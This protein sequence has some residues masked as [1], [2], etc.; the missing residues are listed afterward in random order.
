L[1]PIDYAELARNR[2]WLVSWQ[3]EQWNRKEDGLR[4]NLGS[5]RGR[6]NGYINVDLY[7]EESDVKE[8]IRK[9]SYAKNSVTEIVCHHSLEHLPIRDVYPTLKHWFELLVPNGTIEVGLPDFELS[10]QAFLEA[11]EKDRWEKHIYKVFGGQTENQKFSM[12]GNS[13]PK[14]YFDYAEGQVHRG[15]FSLGYFVRMVEDAGFKIINAFNYDAYGSPSLFVYAMKPDIKKYIYNSLLE[16]DCAIGV[17]THRTTYLPIL[18]AST[19]KYFPQVQFITRINRGMI[20]Q[21]MSLLRE[22]FIKSGKR[23]WIYLDDDIQFLNSN[24]IKNALET[25]VGEKYACVSVY[26]TFE[27]IALD[28]KYNPQREGVEKRSTKWATGYF[29]MVDSQKVG[30]ILPDMGL[31]DGNTAVDTSYSVDIRAAGYDIGNSP[32]YV[33]HLKK[34]VFSNLNVIQITNNYLINKWGQFYFDW[35]KYD[36]NVLD[37]GWLKEGCL[38]R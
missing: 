14:E 24:I 38:I 20:N 19:Q 10:V 8:D 23:Y 34:Q 33:Y 18:W 15:G 25:L 4:L 11:T 5:G 13:D 9:L 28:E 31:P 16:K 2:D 6:I 1:Q 22:D 12:A 26:S 17:F 27:K 21:N 3:H 35:A 30:Y 36:Y 32:D 37:K 29:I 7:T